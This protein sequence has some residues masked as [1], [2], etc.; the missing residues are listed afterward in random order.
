LVMAGAIGV[1]SVR[2][3]EKLP[4]YLIEPAPAVSKMDP[5]LAKVKPISDSGNA[6]VRT[7]L[8]RGQHLQ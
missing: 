1:A 3:C 6:S 7:Y 5:P 2:S 8:R 4:P